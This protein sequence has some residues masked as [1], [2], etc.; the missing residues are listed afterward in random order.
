MTHAASVNVVS[1]TEYQKA[2][3]LLNQS[4][5][6]NVLDDCRDLAL[7]RLTGTLASML[8][9]M[10]D[11]LGELAEKANSLEEQYAFLN[12]RKE[13]RF[14]RIAM[15]NAFKK[16]FISLFSEKTNA[17][18]EHRSASHSSFSMELSLVGDEEIEENIAVSNMATAVQD[19]CESELQALATRMGFLLEA[20]DLDMK[21]NPISPEIIYNAFKAACKQLE[22]TFTVQQALM[23]LFDRYLAKDLPGIYK[24][25]N[26]QLVS[27][28]ILPNIRPG[29]HSKPKP[30]PTRPASNPA[31]G[32]STDHPQEVFAL[33]QQLL[34]NSS[35]QMSAGGPGQTS[36]I[37]PKEVAK[38]IGTAGFL[39]SL[40]RL[41]RGDSRFIASLGSDFD[42][43][44]FGAENLLRQIRESAFASGLSQFDAITIDI[45]AMLFDYIFEDPKIPDAVKA[46]IGRLQIPVLKVAMLDK[47]FFSSRSHPTRKMLDTIGAAAIGRGNTLSQSDPLYKEIER[48]VQRVLIEFDSDVSIFEEL[49]AELES[50]LAAEDKKEEQAVE[51]SA[52]VIHDRE[53]LEIARVIAAE[54]VR[55][56]ID[57]LPMVGMVRQFLSDS[58]LH[59]LT[60][61]HISGGE[62]CPEWKEALRAMDELLWS[63]RPKMTTEERKQL[64]ALLPVLLKRLHGGMSLIAMGD[65]KQKAFFAGLV[66]CHTRAVKAGLGGDVPAP[67]INP[68]LAWVSRAEPVVDVNTAGTFPGAAIQAQAESALVTKAPPASDGEID[69]MALS[70]KVNSASRDEGDW[71]E[72]AASL[73]RGTWVDFKQEDGS[74][75]RYRLSWVSPLKKVYLFTNI[76]SQKALSIYPR[77]MEEQLRDGTAVILHNAPLMDRAVENMLETLQRHS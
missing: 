36:G 56:R 70:S 53:R 67:E 38:P 18:A 2:R 35:Q 21:T 17:K 48:I 37:R 57:G 76:S 30:P 22:S 14:K 39:D 65:E 77:A 29:Y 52:Q 49:L 27:R 33:L 61:A 12:A 62:D 69:G 71:V 75:L 5:V 11:D 31:T 68:S 72:T 47:R 50:F 59:V 3:R 64:V 1:M 58:W 7:K 26:G 54:E 74:F 6:I 73:K 43:Q 10:D 63:V 9:K 24:E 32:S 60:H 41:Q 45:V 44:A 8:D 25:I 19:N 40:N 20:P 46:L 4:E 28:R 42:A 66:A 23:K 51:R 34:M 55:L 13:A 16:H 15:E